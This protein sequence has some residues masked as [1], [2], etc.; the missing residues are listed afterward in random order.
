MLHFMKL[1]DDAASS[2]GGVH[3]LLALTPPFPLNNLR[4][5]VRPVLGAAK[6]LKR[7]RDTIQA[8]EVPLGTITPPRCGNKWFR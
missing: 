3:R 6:D 5:P 7:H 1:W 2:S 8:L 4:L